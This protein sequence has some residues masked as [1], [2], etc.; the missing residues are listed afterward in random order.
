MHANEDQIINT[1]I[2]TIDRFE[3]TLLLELPR[4][5]QNA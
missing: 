1:L 5:A 2:S 4:W 3:S